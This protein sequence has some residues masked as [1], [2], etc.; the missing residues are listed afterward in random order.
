[1][2]EFAAAPSPPRMSPVSRT[3]SRLLN[4]SMG[5]CARGR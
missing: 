2:I 5:I 3:A 1:M 4:D